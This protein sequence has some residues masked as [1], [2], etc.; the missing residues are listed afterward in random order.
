MPL[1]PEEP[2]LPVPGSG[3]QVVELG[4]LGW[5]GGQREG[6][7][8]SEEEQG[9]HQLQQQGNGAV[10]HRS[11]ISKGF[12]VFLQNSSK[13]YT[14]LHTGSVFFPPLSEAVSAA[15][16]EFHSREGIGNC[17]MFFMSSRKKIV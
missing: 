15:S 6:L 9:F 1:G 7:G 17:S 8:A 4:K 16:E 3:G 2:L 10:L 5:Q 12:A 11:K 14:A 13:S